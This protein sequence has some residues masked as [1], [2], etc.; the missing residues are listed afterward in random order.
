MED[1]KKVGVQIEKA[2]WVELNAIAKT[3]F[4]STTALV[5][6][7]ISKYVKENG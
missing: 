4:R 1:K 7:I 2:L 5:R 3:Q 6:M